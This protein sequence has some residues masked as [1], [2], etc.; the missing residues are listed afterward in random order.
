MTRLFENNDRQSQRDRDTFKIRRNTTE[1]EREVVGGA[2]RR[3]H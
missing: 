1:D 3:S 2:P